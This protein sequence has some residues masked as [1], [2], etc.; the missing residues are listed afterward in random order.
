MVLGCVKP[1][2]ERSGKRLACEDAD[3]DTIQPFLDQ[4][5][6]GPSKEDPSSSAVAALVADTT[7]V[8]KGNGAE[9]DILH[10]QLQK[11]TFSSSMDSIFSDK[12]QNVTMS[13]FGEH[14]YPQKVT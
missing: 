13:R 7:L 11:E 5:G 1:R 3:P 10:V 8:Y 4:F 12:V 14:P 9:L 6:I 2:G